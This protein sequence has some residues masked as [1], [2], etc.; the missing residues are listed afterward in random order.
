M[1][2]APPNFRPL[3]LAVGV[4]LLTARNNDLAVLLVPAART[5]RPVRT[6]G[7]WLLPSDSPQAA[8]SLDGAAARIASRAGVIPSLLE[9]AGALGAGQ[10]LAGGSANGPQVS[11]EYFGL[12]PYS[13]GSTP[14]NGNTTWVGMSDLPPL[15]DRDRQAIDIA[16]AAMRARVDVQPIA[17][18]L[19]PAEFT[20][21][22]L[23]AVYEM[24]LGRHLH[25]ASFRR[26]L[27]ASAVVEAT[28]EWRSEGR[29]RPAQLFRYARPQ[30]RRGR[31][32][33]RF[34]L[35]G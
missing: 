25:K 32:G 21:S 24:L 35:F 33:V 16:V 12:V 9:Q 27:H 14:S 10:D 8:E 11:I 31:R 30:R 6:R 18:R 4:V 34:D 3:T 5:K 22:E 19:L 29:G 17:F 7:Q 2:F 26:S 28:D 13:F 15:D 20:L 1:S 23:Q